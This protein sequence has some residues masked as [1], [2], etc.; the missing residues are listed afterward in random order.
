[1]FS[2]ERQEHE[3]S[4]GQK[5][6]LY[7]L[8]FAGGYHPPDEIPFPRQVLF[9][10]TLQSV[11]FK[12]SSRDITQSLWTRQVLPNPYHCLTHLLVM[13][14]PLFKQPGILLPASNYERYVAHSSPHPSFEQPGLVL[15]SSY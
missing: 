4:H 13:P 7:V 3:V 12:D 8:P 15:L 6:H 2:K 14:P 9:T 11:G 5:N 1:M 10:L